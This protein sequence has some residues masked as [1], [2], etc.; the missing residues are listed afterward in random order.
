VGCSVA[1]LSATA[2]RVADK[3]LASWFYL[4]VVGGSCGFQLT[5]G[6]CGGSDSGHVPLTV[7]GPVAN[8]AAYFGCLW[9]CA[10]VALCLCGFLH[11][12]VA[13]PGISCCCA[14]MPCMLPV[15][16][17]CCDQATRCAALTFSSSLACA[18]A[19]I[20]PTP[21]APPAPVVLPCIYYDMY[22]SSAVLLCAASCQ[23]TGRD[24]HSRDGCC[25]CS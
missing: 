2:L 21:G 8:S 9:A 15:W 24:P 18:S 20:M 1:P 16:F 19:H 23:A 25:T 22:G 14:G 5:V 10:A 13:C 7:V 6:S 3:G 12:R 4:E 11:L 17:C